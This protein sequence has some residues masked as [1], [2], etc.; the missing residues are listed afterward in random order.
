MI[1]LDRHLRYLVGVWRDRKITKELARLKRLPRYV[2][3]TT[4][5][6]VEGTVVPDGPSFASAYDAIFIQNAYGFCAPSGGLRIID[7]GANV[8]L[9]TIYLAR[10]F[11]GARI[12]AF[13]PDPKLFIALRSNCCAAGILAQVEL[14]NAAVWTADGVVSFLSEGADGGKVAKESAD[15]TEVPAVR[16][17]NLI[18]GPIDF[19]KVDIEGAEVEVLLDLAKQLRHVERLFVEW[20]SMADERQ[21]LDELLRVISAAGLRYH[22]QSEFASRSPFTHRGLH[23]GMDNQVNVFAYRD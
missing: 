15:T 21:R 16:L 18:D 7:C 20:H 2:A 10:R 17:A 22:L 19:L 1:A 3:T 13:E 12:L 9:A 4:S 11:P 5:L 8:G 14:V 23:A 6:V